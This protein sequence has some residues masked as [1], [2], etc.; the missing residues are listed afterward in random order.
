MYRPKS[1]GEWIIL[2]TIIVAL[3][4]VAG[5]MKQRDQKRYAESGH[6]ESLPS[7]P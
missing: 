1:K 4:C 6:S 7:K 5:Y 3:F 2:T